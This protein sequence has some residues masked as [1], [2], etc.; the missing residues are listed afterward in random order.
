MSN[1]DPCLSTMTVKSTSSHRSHGIAALLS[2]TIALM[3]TVPLFGQDRGSIQ[4]IVE[5]CVRGE[6]RPAAGANVSVIPHSVTPTAFRRPWP[7]SVATASDGSFTLDDVAAGVWLAAAHL[8]ITAPDSLGVE[9]MRLQPW[10]GSVMTAVHE[11]DAGVVRIVLGAAGLDISPPLMRITVGQ[12]AQLTANV[13]TC[14]SVDDSTEAN[15]VAWTTDGYG[16]QISST[17]VVT[18]LVP[19]NYVIGAYSEGIEGTSVVVVSPASTEKDRIV[20]QNNTMI[21]D[22]S[23]YDGAETVV[24]IDAN[25]VLHGGCVNDLV[26]ESPASGELVFEE[27]LDEKSDD[28]N[29]DPVEVLEY[30]DEIVVFSVDDPAVLKDGNGS[31]TIWTDA[32]G[33]LEEVDLF[34][35]LRPVPVVLWIA[36]ETTDDGDDVFTLAMNDLERAS[37]LYNRSRVG[38]RFDTLQTLPIWDPNAGGVHDLLSEIGGEIGSDGSLTEVIG[39][40]DDVAAGPGFVPAVLNVYYVPKVSTSTNPDVKGMHCETDGDWNMIYVAFN[41][42]DEATLAHEFGH[43]FGLGHHPNSNNLMYGF[44]TDSNTNE[45]W[46][47][48]A[49]IVNFDLQSAMVRNGITP[50]SLQRDCTIETL[51]PNEW[52]PLEPEIP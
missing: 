15:Q 3:C 36:G 43:A 30:P 38:I 14:R 41:K 25:S 5:R 18:G 17:G 23:E 46:I 44:N 13:Q 1:V 39:C 26:L 10:Y 4:G 21:T 47:G 51:C 28:C 49:Y 48:Q 40:L 6:I 45:L 9:G 19:G 8:E 7:S 31:G 12:S 29:P 34:D 24:L 32:D 50:A 2:T 35:D 37:Q 27:G 16:V 22:A 33:D 11:G 52:L 42:R 20:V